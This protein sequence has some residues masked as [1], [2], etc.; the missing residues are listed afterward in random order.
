VGR[1][2]TVNGDVVVEQHSAAHTD[3]GDCFIGQAKIV[4]GF[5][6]QAVN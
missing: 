6:D 4:Y 5:G 3:S 2:T 1:F